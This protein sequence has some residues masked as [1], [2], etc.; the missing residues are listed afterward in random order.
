MLAHHDLAWWGF[1]VALAAM[2]LAI[3]INIIANLLTPLLKNWWAERSQASLRARI[4]RLETEL[5]HEVQ[6]YP[7]MSETEHYIFK[8]LTL[9]ATMIILSLSILL[10]EVVLAMGP[11]AV[12]THSRGAVGIVLLAVGCLGFFTV[13]ISF[14]ALSRFWTR[15]SPFHRSEQRRTIDKMKQTLRK[16]EEKRIVKSRL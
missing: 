11:R 13:A 16:R 5:Q 4:E 2:V 3:P 1:A 10:L 14:V 7:A 6:R 9:L 15:R 12:V 8:G